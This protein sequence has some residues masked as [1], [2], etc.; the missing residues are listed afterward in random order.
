[1]KIVKITML[2]FFFIGIVGCSNSEEKALQYLE[3]K[4]GEEFEVMWSKEGSKLFQDLYGGDKVIVHPKGEPNMVFIVKEY[5]DKGEW[6]DDYLSA[7]WGYELHQILEADIAKELPRGTQFKVNLSVG[8]NEVDETMAT[9]S[10]NEYLSK[11]KNVK[12]SLTAGIKT[13]GP[14]DINQYSNGIYN[15]FQLFKGLGVKI[16]AISI[17]FIDQSEDISEYIQTS[18][19]NNLQWS[20]FNAKVYGEVGVD[21]RLDP[22]DPSDIVDPSVILHGPENIIDNY[23]SFME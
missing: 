16:Y 14:P 23:E 11:N 17:G 5:N 22:D 15:L 18:F 10:V 6:V 13:D 12:I 19:V 3:D 7:K 21:D 20:N 9:I 8:S 1:M 2:L 4:Y